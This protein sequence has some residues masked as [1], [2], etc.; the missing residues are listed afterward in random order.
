MENKI[1]EYTSY[2]YKQIRETPWR[3]LTA[4]NYLHVFPGLSL[5]GRLKRGVIGCISVEKY[6]ETFVSSDPFS[7][8]SS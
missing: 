8:W 2:I 6:Y 3:N 4:I 1:T 5:I 7:K